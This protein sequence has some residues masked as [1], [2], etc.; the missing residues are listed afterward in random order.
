MRH[1]FIWYIFYRNLLKEQKKGHIY[2]FLF[3]EFQNWQYALIIQNAKAKTLQ[4]LVNNMVS[5]NKIKRNLF[6]F[7]FRQHYLSLFELNFIFKQPTYLFCS[8]KSVVKGN[9]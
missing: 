5:L 1:L 3:H 2:N 8:E 9:I 6:I 4:K 7:H